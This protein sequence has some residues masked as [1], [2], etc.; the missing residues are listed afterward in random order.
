MG[1][2]VQKLAYMQCGFIFVKCDDINFFINFRFIDIFKRE[3]DLI[4]VSPS[5]KVNCLYF[6]DKTNHVEIRGN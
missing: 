3:M 2:F 6:T 1:T 4:S 5:E